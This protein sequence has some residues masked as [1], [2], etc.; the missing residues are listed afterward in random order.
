MTNKN[1]KQIIGK[2]WQRARKRFHYPQL[3]QPELVDDIPNG[4]IDIKNLEIKISEPFIEGFEKHGIRNEEAMNEVL[5]HELT[6][7]MKFPG[8]V[9]NILRLQ[10]SAQ[11]LTD[12][13]K[14]SELRAAFTEA[15][16][17]LYMT[18]EVQ[19]P[20]T[21][22][23]R[24]AYG[25]Q[26]EDSAG[27]LMYG[28][29]Q[30]VSG[31]DFGVKLTKEERGLVGKLKDIDFLDKKQETSSF[32]KF[33]QVMKDYQPPQQNQ[34]EKGESKGQG[35]GSGQGDGRNSNDPCSGSG[36]EL[37]RFT[38][39]QIREGL[40]Q[41]AQE[42]ST[43]QEYEEIV[44]QILNEDAERGEERQGQQQAS[45]KRAGIGRS[46]TELADNFY[47]ALAEKY[48]IP[49]R[50]KQMHKN[51]SLYPHSHTPFE[52]GD[53]ITEVDA[54][55]TPGILPGI[56][57]KWVRKEGEVHGNEESVPDSFVVVDNSPSMFK[58]NGNEIISPSK[59]IYSH[60]VGATAISNAYLAN[61]ARV[62]VYS[63]GSNDHLT[64]PTK[65]RKAVHSELRRYSTGGGTTFN[66]RF[67]EGV[68]RQNQDEFDISVISDMDISNLDAFVQT[69]LSIPQTHRVH[70]LY[71]GNSGYVNHLRQTFG[72]KDNV[73]IL[74]LTAESDIEKIT[75]GELKKS[76][77]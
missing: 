77:K 25:L 34:D 4:S 22:K 39:N 26:N 58:S 50:K 49:I 43:P 13:H 41:F 52:V 27:R 7:F 67:L 35:Q 19:H 66:P 45:G 68:L 21:A 38:E 48:V 63:F 28:L 5:T 72:D 60:I 20:A 57:K 31:Q 73:A 61:G 56:T 29:Y 54:F 12:R 69:V 36:K 2:E 53:S 37:D 71:T 47:T 30:E 16:T 6:H 64:N 9:L 62:A 1:L 15:Q 46:T 3:P 40:K 65:D 10:K 74:P 11:G 17:N 14:V 75:M 44:K 55:S 32:R 24:K 18:Q 51:G 76:V 23:M 59:R 42:C 33:V 70:L 8:S